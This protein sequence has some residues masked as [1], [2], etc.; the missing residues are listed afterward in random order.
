[1][2]ERLL[3]HAHV[4]EPTKQQVVV[5]LLADPS[6]V[7][8]LHLAAALEEEGVWRVVDGNVDATPVQSALATGPHAVVG[9]TVMPGRQV[10]TAI[11]ISPAI[12]AT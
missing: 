11:E 8:A 1:M 4:Q 6:L 10:P 9:V 3:D 2:V 5:Q 12:R 7:A